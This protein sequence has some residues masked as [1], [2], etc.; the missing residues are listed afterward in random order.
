MKSLDASTG[1]P[2]YLQVARLLKEDIAAKHYSQGDAV[3]SLRVASSELRVNIHTIGK[4]YA[5]LEREGVLSRRRGDAFRVAAIPGTAVDLI[6]EDV[7]T[8]LDRAADLK[9]SPQTVVELV[10]EAVVS[11]SRREA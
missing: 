9:V 8:L 5:L 10:E 11:R 3:P 4:A 7:E 2:L 1:V 6:R